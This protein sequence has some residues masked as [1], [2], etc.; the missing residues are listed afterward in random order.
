MQVRSSHAAQCCIAAFYRDDSSVPTANIFPV[1]AWYCIANTGGAPSFARAK[2]WLG[3]G[4]RMPYSSPS[5]ACNRPESCGVEADTNIHSAPFRAE[6]CSKVPV[7][8][9]SV[10]RCS[11]A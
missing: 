11:P 2:D 7:P 5:R 1:A 6:I 9:E 10:Q 8:G 3:E 4:F